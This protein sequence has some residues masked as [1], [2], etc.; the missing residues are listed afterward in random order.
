[1][2]L[3]LRRVSSQNS[4]NFKLRV[5]VSLGALLFCVLSVACDNTQSTLRD[6][7]LNSEL[8]KQV[9]GTSSNDPDASLYEGGTTAGEHN[10]G[11]ENSFNLKPCVAA[12]RGVRVTGGP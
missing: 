9:A 12:E 3:I 8:D 6:A 1:M 11:D 7:G 5:K 2:S 4:I 10:A